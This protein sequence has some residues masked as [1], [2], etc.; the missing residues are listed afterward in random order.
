VDTLN[1]RGGTATARRRRSQ[2]VGRAHCLTV[3][4]LVLTAVAGSAWTVAATT[5]T[6]GGGFFVGTV[7][8]PFFPCAGCGTTFTGSAALSLAGIGTGSLDGVP[9]PYV[10][11]WPLAVNDLTATVTYNEACANAP[12]DTL[13]PLAGSAGGPLILT[14]G[15]LV[16][17]GGAPLTGATLTGSFSWTRTATAVH[18]TLTDLTVTAT[19]SGTTVAISLTATVTGQS[20]TGFVWT[21]GPGT[22]AANGQQVNQTAVVG[23]LALQAV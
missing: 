3:L 20:A 7:T 6:T 4:L 14:G 8:L 9:V 2:A 10:A 1:A 23:G 17:G 21:N 11:V 18:I 5:T 19:S 22:C 15:S 12:V 13:P 16:L